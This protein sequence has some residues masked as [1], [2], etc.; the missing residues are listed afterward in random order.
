VKP[1]N[2][3]FAVPDPD[4]VSTITLVL[5]IITGIKLSLNQWSVDETNINNVAICL[6][7]YAYATESSVNALTGMAESA[8]LHIRT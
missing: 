2:V 1:L 6:I 4:E 3:T 7:F 5:A 8:C